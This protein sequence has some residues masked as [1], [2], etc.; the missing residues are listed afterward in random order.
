MAG[1]FGTTVTLLVMAVAI[2]T[3]TALV[4]MKRR[5]RRQQELSRGVAV[6]C[7]RDERGTGA[8]LEADK[9]EGR[10]RLQLANAT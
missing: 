10:G 7:N 4:V 5:G 2:V 1:S 9:K 3:C 8:E 6:V